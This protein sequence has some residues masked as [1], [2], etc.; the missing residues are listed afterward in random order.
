MKMNSVKNMGWNE[1]FKPILMTTTFS[2]KCIRREE[3]W[4]KV[5]NLW[6]KKNVIQTKGH[7][8]KTILGKKVRETKFNVVNVKIS[9]LFTNVA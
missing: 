3:G 9:S 2:K 1:P 8:R 6:I 5:P 4:W 7:E